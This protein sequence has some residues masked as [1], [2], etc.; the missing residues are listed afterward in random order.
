MNSNQLPAL[1]GDLPSY[2]AGVPAKSSDVVE[3]FD[4]YSGQRVGSVANVTPAQLEQAI[5]AADTGNPALS[6]YDRQ[7][8]LQKTSQLLAERAEE[9]AQLIRWE[10]GLC[11]RETRYEVGRA[12]DVLQFSAMEALRDDGQ[13][14]SCDLTAHG[15]QRKI[16]TVRE[17]LQLV[18]AIT[19]FNHPLNQVVHK[20]G[21]AVAAGAPVILKPSE[22]TPLT[23][24]RFAE[25]LYEA[26]LPGSML[27]VLLGPIDEVV[28]PLIRDPRVELVSFTG[29]VAVGK[30]I[31]E[32]AGYK[33]LC[34]EL[35]GNSPLIVLADADFELAV[36]LAVQGCFRNS[37][38]RCTAVKRVLVQREIAEAFTEALVAEA[39]KFT[40][41]DPSAEETM[42][43]TVIDEPAA[44]YLETVIEEA[45]AAGARVLCGGERSGA[46]L[47]PTVL[48]DVPRDARMV[49]HESFGPLA[50]VMEIE[51]LSDAIELANSTAYG[52]SAG[53]VTRDIESA[54]RAIR[55]LRTGTVNVNEVPGYRIESSPFGGI[56][57]SGLGVKEG[58]IEAVKWMTYT[59]TFSLPW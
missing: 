49:V 4:P 3:V 9:F 21:P 48:R 19:P 32:T 44:Q 11:M 17:P 27:S 15:K 5:V 16:F 53:V 54:R 46:Q 23:A 51:D 22:K 6:R 56:K 20:L 12:Q 40:C 10:A 43:G 57:D 34:L 28:Q 33:K 13:I 24:V 52:L 14:F 41:G 55:E 29:S 45:V 36:N 30:E 39:K 37:G 7:Q 47:Q 18:A 31:A 8:I 58:V 1:T 35:G 25:L 59:K 50:P 2:I 26:G 38:Q 42:I